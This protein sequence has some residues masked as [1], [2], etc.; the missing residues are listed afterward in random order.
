MTTRDATIRE[1]IA[2]LQ[3]AGCMV[4]EPDEGSYLPMTWYIIMLPDGKTVDMASHRFELLCYGVYRRVMGVLGSHSCGT[5]E[6]A[7]QNDC[8]ICLSRQP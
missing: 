8:E 5:L 7:R 2:A 3:R 6:A 4:W 1:C